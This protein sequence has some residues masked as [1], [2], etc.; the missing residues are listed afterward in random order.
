MRVERVKLSKFVT[1][2]EGSDYLDCD[3]VSNAIYDEFG[4]PGRVGFVLGQSHAWNVHKDDNSIIIDGTADQFGIGPVRGV[5]ILR[6]GDAGY[7]L[8][9]E[10]GC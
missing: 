8:Y 4:H 5:V 7:G 10:E 9:S 3:V 1:E 6:P 2:L